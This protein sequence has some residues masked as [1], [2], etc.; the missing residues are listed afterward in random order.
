MTGFIVYRTAPI[1]L[2]TPRFSDLDPTP[3]GTHVVRPGQSI[4]A[5]LSVA[6]P[7][8]LVIV[9]PGEY[10]ER[11]TLSRGVRLISRVPRAAT[12]RLPATTSDA[13]PEPVIV[14]TGS[15]GELRGFKI[16]GDSRTPL[17]IGVLASGTDVSLVDLEISGAATA[18]ISF[19]TDS[20]A[21][22]V[23]S[24]IH[25]NP[26]AALAIASG[27][28]PRVTHSSFGRNGMSPRTPATFGIDKGARP[29]FERN[30]FVG[31]HPDVFAILDPA[32]RV[33][34]MRDN[35]FH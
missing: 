12:L 6:Q 7:G 31:V 18:A 34:L 28:S 19:A 35:W 14:A 10:R 13:Q 9:E 1:T 4:A 16:V 22:L 3:D 25:D 33:A 5:A 24:E 15:Y 32:T 2:P 30:V 23:G 20:T 21:T 17:G 27:A 8:S 29:L 11:V 26:G